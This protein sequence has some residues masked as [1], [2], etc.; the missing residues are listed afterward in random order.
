L[1][2][3]GRTLEW[4]LLYA[5]EGGK[6]EQDEVRDVDRESDRALHDDLSLSSDNP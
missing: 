5:R 3:I 2:R 1:N 6:H 4:T